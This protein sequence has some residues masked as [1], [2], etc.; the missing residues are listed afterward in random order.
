MDILKFLNQGNVSTNPEYNPKTK[1]GALEPPTLVDFNPGTSYSDRGRSILGQT[2]ARNQYD[3]NQY[4]IDKYAS[5][6]TFVGPNTSQE[7]L[8]KER[9]KNQSVWEQTGR[10]AIQ[11]VTEVLGGVVIGA[12]DIVDAIINVANEDN[13]YQNVIS[14]NLE[15]LKESINERFA[16]YRENPNE[17]FNGSDYGWWMSNVPSLFSS[18]S[19]LV[20]AT[21]VTKVIGGAG[22]LLRLNKFANKFANYY[23]LTEKTRNT[24]SVMAE[25]AVMGASMRLGENYLEARQTHKDVKDYAIQ[26]LNKMSDAD[27]AIFIANNPQYANM[28]NDDIA[29]DI[30]NNSADVTFK[31]DWWNVFFDI[32]QIWGLKNV[33]NSRITGLGG[34]GT[35]RL[36]RLNKEAAKMFGAKDTAIMEA[37][38]AKGVKAK[39]KQAIQDF[40]YDM[41]HLG[42]TEWTEGIEEAVNYI[43]QQEGLYAGKKVFDRNIDA[44]T[45]SDYL[46]DPYMWE[47]AF[48]GVM[49]GLVFGELSSKTTAFVNK[50]FNKEWMTAEKQREA[51]ILGRSNT[52]QQYISDLQ[53]ISEGKN[54]YDNNSPIDSVQQEELKNLAAKIYVDRLVVNAANAGNLDLLESFMHDE[55]FTKGI[56]EKLNISAE[57]AVNIVKRFNESLSITKNA[58]NDAISRA[59]AN[60]ASFE[61]AKLIASNIVEARHTEDAY[62]RIY[63]D[64]ANKLENLLNQDHI[65]DSVNDYIEDAKDGIV[66]S[67]IMK[68]RASLQATLSNTSLTKE[69]R[70]N[71]AREISEQISNFEK[72]RPITGLSDD[73]IKQKLQAAN[74]LANEHLDVYNAYVASASAQNSHNIAKRRAI[75]SDKTIK[76]EIARYNNFLDKSRKKIIDKAM[77]DIGNMFDKYGSDE[78]NAYRENRP[79]NIEE[80]D[81]KLIDNAYTVLD[82]TS[83]SNAELAEIIN[84]MSNHSRLKKEKRESDE[85][86]NAADEVLDLVE[87]EE[88]KPDKSDEQPEQP[89]TGG[90]EQ[91][92]ESKPLNI[93]DTAVDDEQPVDTTQ[94][95][96]ETDSSTPP[97]EDE[98]KSGEQPASEPKAKLN[99]SQDE[100]E[101]YAQATEILTDFFANP[102][103][104]LDDASQ[105]NQQAVYNAAKKY[106]SDLG[107]NEEIA[108]IAA[109]NE[110]DT[111]I[112]GDI[113]YLESS[114]YIRD[115]KG[116][117]RALMKYVA[118]HNFN[119][120]KKAIDNFVN[121]EINGVKYGRQFN[122]KTY[123]SLSDFMNYI[124]SIN[125]DK[126]ITAIAFNEIR[127]YLFSEENTDYVVVDDSTI[128]SI[129]AYQLTGYL[130][131][132]N[133]IKHNKVLDLK[134]E[135]NIDWVFGMAS[136]G[137]ND[138]IMTI[139]S[140]KKGQKLKPVYDKETKRI[141]LVD[142]KNKVIGYLGTAD[143]DNGVY[144]K[145]NENWN[146]DITIDNEGVVHSKLL[147]WL[148][149]VFNENT[150]AHIMSMIGNLN[151]SR[152]D[153][154]TKNK[155]AKDLTLELIQNYDAAK[156]LILEPE[157][158]DDN[159]TVAGRHLGKILR[160]ILLDNKYE[161]N[162][163]SWFNH[164]AA[165]YI[166]AE[167]LVASGK[168]VIIEDIWA[169]NLNTEQTKEYEGSYFEEGI[170]N[171]DEE[172]NQIGVVYG[173]RV[174]FSKS[175][176]AESI[177]NIPAGAN[178]LVKIKRPNDTFAY[179]LCKQ[180]PIK[181][182]YSKNVAIREIVSGVAA[183]VE[184]IAKEFIQKANLN[185]VEAVETAY[186]KLVKLFGPKGLIKDMS[187]VKSSRGISIILNKEPKA[188]KNPANYRISLNIPGEY[189]GQSKGANVYF[190]KGSSNGDKNAVSYNNN[191]F[192]A[193]QFNRLVETI[194]N[195]SAIGIPIELI[196]D[197]TYTD[198]VINPYVFRE[199]GKTVIKL[200]TVRQEYNSY[201]DFLVKNR[202]IKSKI[203]NTATP[204]QLDVDK[205]TV[206][207]VAMG[208]FVYSP[209][210]TGIKIRVPGRKSRSDVYD[211]VVREIKSN[212]DIFDTAIAA[213]DIDFISN[214]FLPDNFGK[215]GAFEYFVSKLAS[216]TGLDGQLVIDYYNELAATG[217]VTKNIQIS[218]NVTE[219]A[220]ALYD[221]K[222]K[223]IIIAANKINE[224]M[225][226]G[227]IMSVA[228]LMNIIVHENIHTK[229][230]E[231]KLSV[232]VTEAFKPIYEEFMNWY[233]KQSDEV[234]EKYK[235]FT[236]HKHLKSDKHTLT[237]IGYEEFMVECLTS[238][239][240][241]ELLNTITTDEVH[242]EK[243]QTLF[244]K[245]MEV[246]AK[247]FNIAINPNSLLAK[248]RAASMK[249]LN[250][251]IEDTVETT[252]N[253]TPSPAP[254][255]DARNNR[256]RNRFR[257]SSI[258][259]SNGIY[260]SMEQLTNREQAQF[261][262]LI[263]TGDIGFVC[264]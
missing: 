222:N 159:I 220:F 41:W 76:T 177:P 25:S 209:Q 32:A 28:N 101:Q 29:Q 264:I 36:N 152:I 123:F 128:Q 194:I 192:G 21:G 4:D 183:E 204:T 142:S 218:F 212:Y 239:K 42:R 10:A 61:V 189:K 102:A 232:K 89:S 122:G 261:A 247:L 48:W 12:A 98:P 217:L 100:N 121:V 153:E 208:N 72:L 188:A 35:N 85:T 71:R 79:N 104:D 236:Q 115:D 200:G 88:V 80:A 233:V 53:A 19:L 231:E 169:G 45:M 8:N 254:S 175:Y 108:E 47:Q 244:G 117:S 245:I 195:E 252:D 107:F 16:I 227:R 162:L 163:Y 54:P 134:N 211:P 90:Q 26:Q 62:R 17:A 172:V 133:A 34:T 92:V 216:R 182:E 173:D 157:F 255:N 234:K 197:K 178:V 5:Y 170:E 6:D 149:T 60:G 119:D 250:E 257:Y 198:K 248:A 31:N 180:V 22:K 20:P 78:V 190:Y 155:I 141:N 50:K 171:Y 242:E 52:T 95:D 109:R 23:K 136:S 24:L 38:A 168:S 75:F 199:N 46:K 137:N 150:P 57:D 151:D 140:L 87:V 9:A 147:D 13:D 221:T 82:L 94:A 138:G 43:S 164:L 228:R 154:E 237:D 33:W 223:S 69:E 125:K 30:A 77:E 145:V 116:V 213:G 40:A 113:E 215:E 256:L 1:K 83:E 251:E 124:Y 235:D 44:P 2:L 18:L 11:S 66:I 118:R 238:G 201:Q 65:K 241:M 167:E 120:V 129:D 181:D 130:Q 58:Y 7:E 73:V 39:T 205:G 203:I 55:N 193:V 14:N 214:A 176:V 258:P 68:L 139:R 106:L 166:A 27:K 186:N 67:N 260:N 81:K 174:T 210:T 225:A 127:N 86:V 105:E 97:V 135:V 179:A 229:I 219:N 262:S 84:T 112:G 160:K 249:V 240:F 51:E 207:K 110:T 224:E 59:N 126:Y 259:T 161:E 191:S 111:Y 93:D 132:Q 246:I 56:K 158:F 143:L 156:F 91:D 148:R 253:N 196:N 114:I 74:K 99:I 185:S 96:G 206:D 37:V 226:K 184:I 146:Y 131:Q 63:I 187:V 49:G 230:D 15:E 243:P 103:I 3:L 263:D 64:R 202:L 70:E 165:S 144:R